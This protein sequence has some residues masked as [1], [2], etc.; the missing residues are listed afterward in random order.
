MATDIYN[1]EREKGGPPSLCPEE[2][3][4]PSWGD[5]A[6]P[7]VQ[8]RGGGKKALS[9]RPEPVLRTWPVLR[10]QLVGGG[11]YRPSRANRGERKKLSHPDENSSTRGKGRKED[12]V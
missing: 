5:V 4:Q 3:L 7:K 6:S 1:Q 11:M 9:R 12:R 2:I 10:G 8:R